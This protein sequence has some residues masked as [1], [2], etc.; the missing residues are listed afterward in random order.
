M[1]SGMK[2]AFAATSASR[3][4]PLKSCPFCT[5]PNARIEHVQ[6][7]E[8]CIEAWVQCGACSAQGPRVEDAYVDHA[9]AASLWNKAKR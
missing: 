2:R 7:G 3:A 5:A 8:D 1:G 6:V 9:S 4:A